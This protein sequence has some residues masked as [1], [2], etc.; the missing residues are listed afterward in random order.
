MINFL[1]PSFHIHIYS[2]IL[3][4]SPVLF[5]IPETLTSSSIF[6]SAFIYAKGT[7]TTSLANNYIFTNI[8]KR[9][10]LCSLA[11]LDATFN[12]RTRGIRNGYTSIHKITYNFITSY[13][14]DGRQLP[15]GV[16]P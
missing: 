1:Q 14:V 4:K 10:H 6:A 2:S 5:I 9:I 12:K 3:E 13:L 16:Y 15:L 11:D 8:S 7:D